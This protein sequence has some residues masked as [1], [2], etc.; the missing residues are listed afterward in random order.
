MPD[1]HVSITLTFRTPAAGA[2][3]LEHVLAAVNRSQMPY[4]LT[5]ASCM[6]FDLDEVED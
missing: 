4:E 3:V 1:P 2:V 5:A 6:S